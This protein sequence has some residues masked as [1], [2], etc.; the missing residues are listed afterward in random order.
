MVKLEESINLALTPNENKLKKTLDECLA[1]AHDK[2]VEAVESSVKSQIDECFAPNHSKMEKVVEASINEN[3]AKAWT[4]TILGDDEIPQPNSEAWNTVVYGKKRRTLPQ[5]IEQTVTEVSRVQSLNEQRKNNI[6]LYKVAEPTEGETNDKLDS[7]K[8]VVSDLMKHLGV[9]NKP[10]KIY[11]LGKFE[12]EKEGSRPIRIE[13][14]NEEKVAEVM[15]QTKKLINA[16]DHLKHVSVS[17]DL[18]EEQRKELKSLIIDAK[19]KEKKFPEFVFKVRG[20]P[21][22][23]RVRSFKK[24]A[25]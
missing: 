5:V 22:N 19:D 16:P 7:D 20:P 23:M 25:A 10:V 15:A 4:S 18:S 24:S 2:F 8:K 17:Y 11:R 6:I 21:G 1:P 3:M 14:E 13:F 12:A 9:N